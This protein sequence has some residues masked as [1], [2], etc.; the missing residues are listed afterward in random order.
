M[1]PRSDVVSALE[2]LREWT[3]W[4]P[5]TARVAERANYR[6]E[7]CGLDLLASVENY[8]LFEVDNV[9]LKGLWPEGEFLFKNQALAC[10]HCNYWRRQCDPRSVAPP[11]APREQLIE[12]VKPYIAKARARTQKEVECVRNLVGWPAFLLIDSPVTSGNAGP[13]AKA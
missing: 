6:C 8:K 10:R 13:A 1:E 4:N 9:V 5:L 2:A 11:G 7:Y 3:S 12:A